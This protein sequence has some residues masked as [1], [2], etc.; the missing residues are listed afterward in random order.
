[1]KEYNILLDPVE[2]VHKKGQAKYIFSLKTNSANEI[3]ENWLKATGNY[4][5]LKM[6]CKQGP[7][8]CK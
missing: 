5:K 6:V 4:I 8:L 7:D 1:M 2:P 3:R